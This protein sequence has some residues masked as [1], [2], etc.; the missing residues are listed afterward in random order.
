MYIRETRKNYEYMIYKN[1]IPDYDFVP[2][3]VCLERGAKNVIKDKT[4]AH[5]HIRTEKRKILKEVKIRSF[6]D[7]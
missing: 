6:V 5:T 2:V 7:D 4:H 1:V 3:L